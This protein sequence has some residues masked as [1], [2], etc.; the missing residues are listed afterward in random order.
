MTQ[1]NTF[2]QHMSAHVGTEIP[3]E[4]QKKMNEATRKQITPETRAF[5][6]VLI[7]LLEKGTISPYVPESLKKTENYDKLSEMDQDKVDLD[8]INL[9][10][11]I[12]QLDALRKL[13][14]E[15]SFQ[16]ELLVQHIFQVKS[17]LEEKVGDVL[18][19]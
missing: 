7:D 13:G 6:D 14:Q 19:L 12:K 15:E 18:V 8:A 5:L 11:Y 3:P 17:R 9:C 16:G 2:H 4:L 10:H 1:E